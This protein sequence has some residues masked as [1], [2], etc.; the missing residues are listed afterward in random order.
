QQ[1]DSVQIVYCQTWQYDDA[2]ARLSER[3]GADPK[4]SYYSGIGGTT[5]QQ[6]VNAT[7]ERMLNG[8]LDLALITS[9]EAL[10]TQ[11]LYKKRGE[12]APYSFK[13]DEKRPFPWESAPDPVE[14]AHEVFQAWLTFAVFDNARRARLAMNLDDYRVDIGR[15]LE[16]MTK[17][18]AAN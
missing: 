6:L 18:A 3:I 12:R 1:L 9:A 5:T 17:V 16:P 2:C 7:A 11:R 10:A 14:V 15:M 4:H 8:D 13:P